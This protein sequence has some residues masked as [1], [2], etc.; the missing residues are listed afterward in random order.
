M[1]HG[2]VSA[3]EMA[4]HFDC[5]TRT[6]TKRVKAMGLPKRKGGTRSKYDCRLLAKMYADGVGV[7]EIAA[8]LGLPSPTH[9]PR[10]IAAMGLPRRSQASGRWGVTVTADEWRDGLLS[11]AMARTAAQEQASMISAE[12]ADTVPGGGR[13][14][15]QPKSKRYSA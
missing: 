9:V 5:S 13:L 15:G 2:G 4:A 6:I 11:R 12:M 10:M 3:A 8:T 1:W 7:R 14:V